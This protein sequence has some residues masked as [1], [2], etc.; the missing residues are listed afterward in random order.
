ML[1][2]PDVYLGIRHG[3]M[4]SRG[5][6]TLSWLD[7]PPSD[8]ATS[9]T[10]KRKKRRRIGYSPG[11]MPSDHTLYKELIYTVDV[12][13][14]CLSVFAATIQDWLAGTVGEKRVYVRIVLFG[15]QMGVIDLVV[16]FLGVMT[17]LWFF[18]GT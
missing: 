16:P 1:L 3:G 5:C 17:C 4:E 10:T 14:R 7:K 2:G 11:E 9:R 6:S 18:L 8:I 15:S 13:K 12:R